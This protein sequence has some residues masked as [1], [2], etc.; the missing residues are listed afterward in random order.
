MA[1]AQPHDVS[2]S[3]SDEP[4]GPVVAEV[5]DDGLSPP[6]KAQVYYWRELCGVATLHGAA[7]V[8]D[9]QW[10]PELAPSTATLRALV[11]RGLFVRRRRAWRLRRDWY[12]RVGA[13]RARA[14]PTPP[15]TLAERPGP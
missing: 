5:F 13:L 14:V 7:G 12:T 11:E 1:T 15:L 4:S 10:P 2:L 8:R 6:T 9:D 3:S